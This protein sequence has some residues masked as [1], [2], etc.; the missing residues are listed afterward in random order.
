VRACRRLFQEPQWFADLGC[1]VLVIDGRGSPSRGR[2]WERAF[3]GD[4]LTPSLEDQVDGLEHAVELFEGEF[5]LTRVAMRGWSF[6]GYLS[7]AAVLRRPD[8]FAAGIAGAPVADWR[9]YDTVASERYL[10]DPHE[11]PAAYE[12]SSLLAEAATLSRPLLLVH[13]LADDNVYPVHS[14][15]LADRMNAVQAPV[16]LVTLPGTTHVVREPATL[17]TLL[18]IQAHFLQETIGVRIPGG[19]VDHRT[20]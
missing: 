1:A 10:G 16:R 17:H 8:V 4:V 11:D 3:R 9:W 12:R 2:N 5:D 13:G 19:D 6:G 18:M 15:A 7:A 14:F 20:S